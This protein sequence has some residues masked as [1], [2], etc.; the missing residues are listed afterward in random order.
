MVRCCP[1]FLGDWKR[2]WFFLNMGKLEHF[3]RN[4]FPV[5]LHVL[6]QDGHGSTFLE[7]SPLLWLTKKAN[8][9]KA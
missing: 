1:V 5:S 4:F 2:R 7:V 3:E 8:L 6:L 9:E